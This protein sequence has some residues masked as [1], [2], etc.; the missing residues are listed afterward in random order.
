MGSSGLHLTELD[1][2]NVADRAEG[3][4]RADRADG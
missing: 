1:M 4:K 3:T 2:T